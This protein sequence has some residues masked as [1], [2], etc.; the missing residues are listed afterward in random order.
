MAACGL[1]KS[2]KLLARK[3]LQK[4]SAARRILLESLEARQLLAVGPQLLSIQP[5]AGDLLESGDILNVSPKELVF[6]FDDGAGIDPN[7]L[8]GI[9]IVRSGEDGVFERATR[10][11]D[12]G[13]G[14]ATLVEFYAQEAGEAGNG[15]ELRFTTVNRADS[16]API[17]RVDGRTIDI[18]LNSNPSLETRVEDILQAFDQAGSTAASQLVYALRLR[19][20]QTVGIAS[21]VDTSRTLVLTGANAAKAATNFNL[22][23]NLEVRLIA[24]EGGNNGLG[25]SVSVTARDRGGAG[26]P[27]VNVDGKNINVELNSNP[28]YATTVQE[29]VDAIN[30]SDSFSSQL[31]EAQLVSGVGATRIGASPINYSPLTLTGVTDIE[32]TPAYVG[33]GDSDREVLFRF[34]EPLPDD[35]YRIEI[36]GQ[37][38]RTLQNVNGETFDCGI[39]K[40]VR[41]ELQTGAQVASVVPQPVSRDPSSGALSWSRTSEID[42]YLN[43]D[44]MLDLN[45]IQS[46]NGLTISQITAERGTLYVQNSDTIVFSTGTGQSGVLDPQFYQLLSPQG[47]LDTS[48][49]PAPELPTRIRYYPNANRVSLRFA[50]DLD[51]YAPAGGELRL[52]IGTNESQ[53]V[54]P[55]SV[56]GLA[57]D[58]SDTFA[59]A[60]DLSAN[61]SPGAAGAQSVIIDSEI[62][63][64]SALLLDFPGGSDEPGNRNIRIQDNLRLGADTIDGTSV[65]FYNFQGQLGVLNGSTLLNAI[66]E[67]QKLRVREVMSLYEQYLGVR[68]VE[69]ENLGMTIGV[70]DMRAIVPF[71]DVVGGT[72]PGVAEANQPGLTVYEAGTLISNGQPAT[73]LDIQDFSEASLNDFGGE[74]MRASMQAVGKLLGMGDADELEQMTIQSFASVFAPGVGTEIVLPGDADIVHGQYLFRPDSKDIDLYQFTLPVDGRISIEA[75][76]ERMGSASLLDSQIR[77]FQETPDGWEAIASNDDY[78]SS[79]SFLELELAQG[80]YI[81]GVSASGNSNYDPTIAD[82]GIGGRSEGRYQLRMD[83]QPPAASVL[84]D[85]DSTTGTEF[86]GDADGNPGGVFNFW[87]RPSGVA[88]TKFVD[89]AAAA[90]GNGSIAAPYNQIDTAIAA[91]TAGDVVRILGN[92]GADGSFATL[93]DNQAYEIGFDNLG[94]PLPDGTTLDVP[95]DVSVMIDAGA[96]LKMRRARVGVGS[97]SVNV[98]RSGGSL[99]VLGTPT[100]QTDSGQVLLD[101]AGEALSGDVYFTSLNDAGLGMNANSAVVGTV[102]G[103]GDWGG[104]DFRTRVDAANETRDNLEEDGLFLNWVSHADIRYGGGQVVVDGLSQVIAPIQ[105]VDA[106]PSIVNSSIVNSADAAMSAT[107]NSF[108]ESNFRSPAEQGATP[109]SVD[110]DRVGPEIHGNRLTSN[111][112]NGLQVRVRT[113]SEVE[114]L[115]VPGRF[116]DTDIVHYIPE[117]LEIQGTPGGALQTVQAPS[118]TRTTLTGQV[119]GTLAAGTYNYR[120]TSVDAM[121]VESP[122]SEPTRSLTTFGTGS[123]VI[124]NLATDVSRIYRSSNAGNGPYTLVGQLPASVGTFID[125]GADLGVTLVDQ[126]PAVTART[127]ARL[128]IDPGTIIKSQGARIDVHMGAQLIAEGA[129]GNDIVFTSLN[130][131]RYGAGGTFDTANRV[132]SQ[133]AVEGDWGGVYVGHTSKASLDHAVISYG[134]GTTRVEGGFSDFSA[135]EVHQA[136]L[137][138][139]NSRIELNADGATTTT[140][141][142]RGGRGSNAAASVFIRASQP[143]LVG[144]IIGNNLGPAI[145][146]NVSSLNHSAVEDYGRSTGASDRY[147]AGVGNRGPLIANNRLDQNATNGLVVRGGALTT[148]GH[149]DDTDI[150]HVVLDEIQIPDHHAFGGLRL[151]SSSNQ[152]LV[153]KLEGAN[154]GFTATGTPLDNANRIGGS[155]QLVGQPSFPV[156][157][158]SLSDST[159]GAGF[160][161][162]GNIQADTN[163]FT[164]SG[165]LPTGPEVDNGTLIDNDVTPGIPGQF[166]FD[167]GP[168][169]S[170]NFGGTGGISAQG[171][172]Q[173]FVNEDVIFDFLN[174]VDVGGNGNAIDLSTSTITLAPTLIAPDLVV[175]EGTFTGANGEVSWRVESRMDNGIA[176]VFN[177]IILNSATPLGDLQVINYLDED[178]RGVTDDIMRVSG[179]PGEEDFRVFTLDGPER[180]GFSQGGVYAATP[181]E[182]ENASYEGW[183]ADEY[184]DL[185]NIIEGAGTTYTVAGNIDTTSLPPFVD[186]ELGDAYGPADI[187][188]AFAWRV[189]PNSTSARITSFLELVPRNP[190][191]QATSGDWAGVLLDTHSN[192]RNVAVVNE[193]ES[194]L[195]TAPRANETPASGQ[196]LGSLAPDV[197]SGDENQRLGFHIEA[198]IAAPSDVDVYTFTAQAG[199]E[200][201]LDIDRTNN[202]LDTVIEL[203]D[204]DGNTLALSDSSLAEEADPSLLYRS[205]QITSTSVNPLRSSPAELYYTSAQGAPKDLFST[206]SKDAGLRVSLPGQAGASNLYHIR[207]RSSNLAAGD[208]ATKLTDPAQVA[209]GLTKGNYLLQIRLSEVDEVPGSSINY[210]DIRFAQDGIRLVGV[211]GNSPLL[212]ENGEVELRDI[213]G[214]NILDSND[215]FANAQPLG[216]LLQTNLQ[217]LSVG[218]NLDSNADV[219]WFSFDIDYQR[220]RPTSIREY[221]A[222]VFDID[223]ANGIGRP[224]TSMYVFDSGGNLILGGLGSNVVD[225]QASPLNAADNSDL[226]RGSAGSLDPYIGSYEL[227]SGTYFLAITNSSRMPE[228]VSQFTDPASGT[229]LV[230]LQ[231]IESIQLIAEDH[232]NGS[233]GS[234]AAGP[235]VPDLFVGNSAVVDYGLGDI[236]LYVSRDAGGTGFDSAQTDIF[237][238]NPFTGEE[239][240]SFGRENFDVEDIAFRDNGELRAYDRAILGGN[241]GADPDALIDY[242]S[243]DTG[244]GVF[245]ATGTSG[246]QT[247]H[248]DT[249]L[250]PPAAAPSNDGVHPE[251]ITFGNVNGQERGFFVGNRPTPTGVEPAFFGPPQ[252]VA[253]VGTARPGPSYF[254]NILFEFDEATGTATSGQAVDKAGIQT[255]QDA[256]TAVRERGYIE[257]RDLSGSIPTLLVAREATRTDAGQPTFVIRDGDQFRLI[258]QT[259]GL[260]L[261]LDFEF[262]FGPEALINYD[263]LGGL[264]VQDEM[265]F[266]VDG[267]TYEFDTGSILVMDAVNGTQLTD[268]TTVRVTN[269]AGVEVIFE[270]DNNGSAAG[271]SNVVISYTNTS[272]R[273]EMIRALVDAINFEPGFGVRAEFAPGSNRISLVGASDTAPAVVTGSGMSIDGS[274]GVTDPNVIRIPISEFATERQLVD[275]IA[276][277][278]QGGIVV[279]YEAG[280][281]NFSGATTADFGDLGSSGIFQDVGSSGAV[282]AGNIAVRA[283]STDTAQ[284]IADRIAQT[285]NDLGILGLSATTN[286]VEIQLFGATIRTTGPLTSGGVAPG[287]LVTGIATVGNTLFAV[288]DAGGLYRVS[289]PHLARTGNIASYVPSAYE[290]TGINFNGLVAGPDP[291]LTGGVQVLFGVDTSGVIHAFDTSGRP[292]PV[293][294]NGATT[295]NTGL[296]GA[297]GLALSPLQS[298]PWGI[299]NTNDNTNRENDPGHGTPATPNSTRGAAI[300]SSSY[301]FGDS[302]AVNYN[303]AGGAAGALESV[304]FSLAGISTAD[305]PVLYFSYFLETEDQ[306]NGNMLDAFRVYASG[307]DGN[308]VLLAT[309]DSARTPGDIQELFDNTGGWRQARIPL[310][311]LA[312]QE[313]VKLRIEFST[314]ASFGYGQ[315]G[316]RGPEIRT[317]AGDR[318]VDGQTLTIGGE[319]FEIEMGPTLSLPSGATLTSG[320]SITVEGTRYVFTDGT[321]APV[322]APDVAVPFQATD[323]AGQVAQGLAN[324]INNSPVNIPV[325]GGIGFSAEENEVVS[326]ATPSGINGDTVRVVGT[327]NIGDNVT[328]TDAGE[329]VDMVRFDVD[330]GTTVTINVNASTIGSSLDTYLRVFDEQGSEVGSNDNRPG[331]SDS[332]F[333]FTSTKGGIYYIGVSGAGNASYNA[334]LAG[335]AVPGSTGDYELTIEVVRQ[336]DTVISGN[337][338]Q[339]D[340]AASVRVT[341]GTPI[342]LQG[343]AGTSGIAV[344]VTAD[345]TSQQVAETLQQSVADYFANGLAGRYAIRGGDTIDLTGLSVSDAGPFGLTTSFAAASTGSFNREQRAQANNFEGVYVD[346]FI[347]GVAGRG[348]MVV[349]NAGG[350]TNFIA[351]PDATN[352]ILTGPYQFEI[353]GGE[354]Y[355][356]PRRTNQF[357]QFTITDTFTP[358]SRQAPGLSIQFNASSNM[359]AGD[360]F[361]VS[362]GPNVVT[363]ELDDVN[364]GRPVTAGNIALPFNTAVLN[365]LTGGSSPESAQVIAARFRDLLNSAGV[366]NILEVAGNLINNDRIGATSDTVVLIGNAAVEIPSSIGTKIVS[367][368]EGATNRERTQGQIVI[369]NSR[370]SN[371]A[372]F[373]VTVA[374]APRDATTNAPVPG[375]PRNT[376]T[377]NDDRLAPGA[378]IMNSEFV[379]NG[380]G[381]ISITGDSAAAGLPP[382]AVPFA[383]LVNNTVIGGVV[384]TITEFSPLIFDSQVFD[385]GTLAFADNVVSYTNILGGTAPV[386]GLDNPG[387]ALGIP[388][389]SGVGEPVAGQ[390][391]VSLGRGGQITLEFTNNL[392]TG[393][394]DA[395]PDLQIFEVGDSEEVTVEVSADGARFTP[396]GRASGAAGS[397]DLDAYGFN[398]NSRLAYVRLTDVSIQGSQSGDSVGADIDAVGAISSVAADFYT[399]GGEGITVTNNSTATLLNNVIVNTATGINVDASSASTVIGGTTFQR[400]V[401]DVAG[402]ATLGQF[403]TVVASSVPMFV[404]VGT[405]NLYPAA[406]SPVIDSSIDS[407][408][409]RPSF[410]AVKAPLG[411][412]ASPILSP[413]TDIN[414]QLRVDDP[415]VETP[416]GLG[417][418]VFK[419]RG[420]QDRADFVGPS[421][422]VVNPADNDLNGVDGNPASSI[423]ELTNATLH[424]FDI[425]LFDGLEPMDPNLGS[426]IDHST[427]SAASVL[428][429][430]NNV[431]MVQGVDYTFGYDSTN[432]II[433][434]TPLTGVWPSESVYTVRFVNT[435]ESAITAK[436]ASNYT[437][438]ESF[439]VIDASGSRTTF[440]I[441]LGYLIAVPTTNGVDADV[442]DAATFT[443]DDGI[444]RLVFELDNNG[445]ISSSNQLVSI[446]TNAS[447]ESVG[448]AIQNAINNSGLNVTVSELGP[449]RLQIQGSRLTQLD[450]QDSGLVVNGT[451]GVRTAFGIQIPLQAG[452]PSGLSDGQTFTI[453][454]SGSPVSFELDTNGVTSPNNI[455]VRYQASDSAAQIA[456]ALI[457]AI[458]SAALGLSPVYAG[459]GQLTLGGDGNT[460]LDMSNTGLSQTGVAAQP[461]AIAISLPAGS[462]VSSSDVAAAIKTAIDGQ[463]LTG[464]TTSQ[465]GGQVIVEGALGVAGTGAGKIGSIKDLAGNAMKANQADGSTS[466]TIFMGEGLDFGDAAAPYAST[467]ADNGPRHTVVSGLSLGPTVTADADAKLDDA[468]TD[469]GL[470]FTSGIMAAFQTDLEITVNNT[471]GSNA[472]MSVWVDFNGDGFFAATES[473]MN[474]ALVTQPTVPISFLVPS[475]AV[476]GDSYVRVRLSTDAAAVASPT[477]SAPDGE[478]E[479]HAIVIQSNPYQNSSNRLDVSGDGFVSP[480]DVLQVINYLN[481]GA[482][483][484]L[485]LPAT[486]TPPYLDVNGDAFVTAIDVL[487]IV[488]YLNAQSAAGEGESGGQALGDLWSGSQQTVLASDWA[489]G[490]ETLLMSQPK[491]SEAGTTNDAALLET[492]DDV[493]L[494]PSNE[495]APSLASIDSVWAEMESD[496][497]NE[498]FAGN[499]SLHDSLDDAL[500]G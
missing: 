382:A 496:Q 239:A 260:P 305:L 218:G 282:R 64:T 490:L 436:Q 187:T 280:R 308:W 199:T 231:P 11:T 362:D 298:N 463:N 90:G 3:R 106:R 88:N 91:A 458:N 26:A 438:G 296:R 357:P 25:I 24:R 47:T 487:L 491:K 81:V 325:V 450:V 437:D 207:V 155:I 492:A 211:P 408:E 270:F 316:G 435:S 447:P 235:I 27:I 8:D 322:I 131:N 364:D 370:V 397:I 444:R 68:F 212:G 498:D 467:S 186:P 378:V 338:L 337:R 84:R 482:P 494:Q 439:D 434:L 168:A 29:F 85:G 252:A 249:T 145:S 500:L 456:D 94:Q 399:S 174:Y 32:V 302:T 432:G 489:P 468:D 301:Y 245:T 311:A 126:L 484:A 423:V 112:I 55:V 330:A 246:L 61:W 82:S 465:F 324:A 376:V 486:G 428:L 135:L 386:A 331:S 288:S 454:R 78:Y 389:Y 92:A 315:Q 95:K 227:P 190:A 387:D 9:R 332:E 413:Q 250:N 58:P 163:N 304:P 56:D 294:A 16:R 226:S 150:V 409:D 159:V 195:S 149:W 321:G 7:S 459:N 278:I 2:R 70:G 178:I 377:L 57:T 309:N 43:D 217:A 180:V 449:G 350:N 146:T 147:E 318:L 310:D 395:N 264:F 464:V 209:G 327:G 452:S 96:I 210:A 400:N 359:I 417:E 87:F 122:A 473:V 38:I 273:A 129:D 142:D 477:G 233:S 411:L 185:A 266:V 133:S 77:L 240:I 379:F 366:Q 368:G 383:R 139:T 253:N 6:R 98:D 151:E 479:D 188:T 140:D 286:G 213:D 114:K 329:D 203:V 169:G 289:S 120:F 165:L 344:P 201:W 425:Q 429:Y 197:K 420:A 281:I 426:G 66:T 277:N 86:D 121:G 404:G 416:S 62:Q 14:G 141:V 274:L 170:S 128:V 76:A 215:A 162:D 469:D 1:S 375:S 422:V 28:R 415:S 41:F 275:A 12:F 49:D 130:D 323:T 247:F 466:L 485:T 21:T 97:T 193:S 414:G 355:G 421:V 134:G 236:V 392:I 48:D 258:D 424:Y 152:S 182:L 219:D 35:Q 446:G 164:A 34:A 241:G 476:A 418:N 320:D 430:R 299:T 293:F 74:F 295:I 251:A 433:R 352:Q 144:N 263:P 243:V 287:G 267:T 488:N 115:S 176:K 132:G 237:A 363:F 272:T 367:N 269:A 405:G 124:S 307:E 406:S 13:T 354:E 371:S 242:I 461:A 123:V 312:G 238:V 319:R 374:P 443:L 205:G 42:V 471:T 148:E 381:G 44:D 15:I 385:I 402:S 45:S 23:N 101:S 18:E 333:S 256:G 343:D 36:L 37:G 347:I 396:V 361:T 75:F 388:N 63:N 384:S 20:S 175:S 222:T 137:R 160:K 419:D 19:G 10:A 189:N 177:T 279:S 493:P 118:T 442:S 499:D 445:S 157:L 65:I 111:S 216:N 181:G 50:R 462:N 22:G 348:E 173:L 214:D 268:S 303:F 341:P 448:R 440:E 483:N 40:S 460:V 407:L 119:G 356:I 326:Q 104:I 172:T 83:F 475:T 161:L 220:I 328:L 89:K 358:T 470:T 455:A 472:Y 339:L 5:N 372:G 474:S 103:A 495:A 208:A 67:T 427:V 206:N 143:I 17:V 33:L 125:N 117:N 410:V 284:T 353:R 196:Y 480:I 223:Y 453:D 192:D 478:V 451:P 154:A 194:P 276:G 166:S 72:A 441:D 100:L 116:D 380:A 79:D 351:N 398:T 31:V 342:R 390:G 412:S 153:V 271:A 171:N 102:P 136:D 93:S 200:V 290:L 225:D 202:A 179:T 457:T 198:T 257:T 265:Q 300:G 391:A 334:S 4:R 69:S 297:N 254:S 54:A 349:G 109:F 230:R 373:G 184:R 52:R 393:S 314:G 80:N 113:P 403:P 105:M 127:D 99:L 248:I 60:Q 244:T 234:T 30:A 431:P 306:N 204:A 345:M 481:S 156:I 51:Q 346:D 107:P 401:A 229:P 191:S 394:G 292:Q 497:D 228:A 255:G 224:D 369:S 46:V 313:N 39:S 261:N 340:G 317:I 283:L 336:V 108:L 158:T 73:I 221:F 285:I 262:D 71:P 53:P 59:D 360:T 167:V 110:Y 365:P 259:S 291:S 335:T 183:A 138:L 232:V